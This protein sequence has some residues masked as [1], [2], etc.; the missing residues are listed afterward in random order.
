MKAPATH[1]QRATGMPPV[2]CRY[3]RPV[4]LLL[5]VLLPLLPLDS[6]ASAGQEDKLVKKVLSGVEMIAPENERVELPG[7]GTFAT[8]HRPARAGRNPRTGELIVIRAKGNCRNLDA[9]TKPRAKELASRVSATFFAVRADGSRK[10]LGKVTAR[11]GQ[12]GVTRDEKQLKAFT[13]QEDDEFEVELDL[14]K[15]APL[16]P[17]SLFNATAAIKEVG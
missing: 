17:C 4:A 10:K 8:R 16:D 1:P 13:V 9:T 6:V 5:L 15:A 11:E 2:L 14:S 7:F 12:T 3:S